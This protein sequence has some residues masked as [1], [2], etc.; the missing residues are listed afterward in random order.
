MWERYC[1][2]VDA[3]VYACL[4]APLPFSGRIAHSSSLL[5]ASLNANYLQFRG[6]LDGRELLPPHFLLLRFTLITYPLEPS[7]P[8]RRL[9]FRTSADRKRS[10]KRHGLS[11]IRSYRT[12]ILGAY[13]Y[14]LCVDSTCL[15]AFLLPEHLAS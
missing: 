12:R 1:N 9:P 6:R 5:T 10:L 7:S 14:L 11:C 15:A 4:A 13:P 8:P 2:G 3:I